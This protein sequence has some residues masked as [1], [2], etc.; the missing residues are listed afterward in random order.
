VG[1]AWISQN[2]W[3][4]VRY[5]VESR[6]IVIMAQEQKRHTSFALLA[7]LWHATIQVSPDL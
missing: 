2:P 6:S 4:M 3:F 5:L 1:N 7:K